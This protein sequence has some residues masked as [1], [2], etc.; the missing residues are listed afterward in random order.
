MGLSLMSE[1]GYTVVKPRLGWLLAKIL[2]RRGESEER[3]KLIRETEELLLE[4]KDPEDLWGIQIEKYLAQAE[5]GNAATSVGKIEDLFRGAERA[6]ILVIAVPAALAVS[7]ILHEQRLDHAKSWG[8]LTVGLEMAERS[9]M[10]EFTWQLSYRM[11]A[12]AARAGHRKESQSKFTLA[13][14]VL[15]Q[16]VG[17]LGAEN[18]RSYL[19]ADHVTSAIKDMDSAV[20][21]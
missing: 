3:E 4:T 17:E 10:R 21:N 9:G 18:Q 11:G 6:R 12:L 5:N 2:R 1:H 14:R 7:E 19:R 8:L 20:L 13:S 16:I 15:R